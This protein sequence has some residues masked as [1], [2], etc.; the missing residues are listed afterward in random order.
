MLTRVTTSEAIRRRNRARVL[1]ALIRKG[2]STRLGLAAQCGL[3][4]AS[5]ANMIQD[6]LADGLV[7]EEGLARSK[8][9]RPSVVVRADKDAAFFLGVD[10]GEAGVIIGLY[11]LTFDLRDVHRATG[12]PRTAPPAQVSA[13][14]SVGLAELQKRN[15]DHWHRVLGLGLGLPGIVDTLNSDP[16]MLYAQNLGWPPI[17]VNELCRIDGIPVVPDNGAKAYARAELW[18]GAIAGPAD[19]AYALVV[20]LGSGL[21]MGIL[22]QG[23]VMRGLSSSA[24]ELG[25]VKVSRQGRRCTCGAVGCL[26]AQMGGDALYAQWREAGGMEFSDQVS[27]ARYIADHWASDELAGR[28]LDDAIEYLA[29]GLSTA[30][31]ILNPSICVIGGWLGEL[32]M[33]ARSDEIEART[34]ALSLR[35][36]AEQ[37]R[38]VGTHLGRDGVALGAAIMAFEH[39]VEDSD[40]VEALASSGRVARKRLA[41][42]ASAS[43][44]YEDALLVGQTNTSTQGG[45]E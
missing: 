24:G 40:G 37:V 42:S 32:M 35:H 38:V 45:D 13:A 36:P 2:P 39:L 22:S 15:Q 44:G 19:A 1:E 23:T 31:N 3:S 7:S 4:G 30:V 27:C 28:V 8:G 29:T 18:R 33:T 21:G 16:A 34:K 9:G 11:D 10:V 6:L 20:V 14:L 41:Q 25:H 5:A 12:L 17:Q 26:E 43:R